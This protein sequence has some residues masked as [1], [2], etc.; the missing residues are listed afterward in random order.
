VLKLEEA[1]YYASAVLLP[2]GYR[3]LVVG[4]STQGSG[5]GNVF[6]N[7]FVEVLDASVASSPALCLSNFLLPLPCQHCMKALT[8]TIQL[9][10]FCPMGRCWFL[11]AGQDL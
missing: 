9:C 8:I 5:P 10:S 1:R 6:K 11:A 4:G 3:V 7:T 2:D